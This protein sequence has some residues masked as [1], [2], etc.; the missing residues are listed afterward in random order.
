[1]VCQEDPTLLLAGA[2]DGSLPLESIGKWGIP[3]TP[4]GFACVGTWVP[5]TLFPPVPVPGPVLVPV[6]NTNESSSRGDLLLIA[7]LLN[8]SVP[9]QVRLITCRLTETQ[10]LTPGLDPIPFHARRMPGQQVVSDLR[11]MDLIKGPKGPSQA[12]VVGT[13][14]SVRSR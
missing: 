10:L 12:R 3:G 13:G 2:E 7:S 11:R 4:C 8:Q 14:N 5:G 6:E 9:L 1:M